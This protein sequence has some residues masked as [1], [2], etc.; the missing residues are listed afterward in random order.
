LGWLAAR[1][2]HLVREI[3]ARGHEVASHGYHHQLCSGQSCIDLEMDL[4][5]SKKLLEDIL[6]G[7]VYGYRAPSFSISD[8]ILRT[9]EQIG[10]LYDS[11]YNSFGMH[12]RYGKISLNGN[13]RSGI[14]YRISDGFYELPISNL[15]IRN[16]LSFELSASGSGPNG[17][18]F[19]LPWGGGAYFRLTPA[20][21]FRKGLES[22][23]A[24]Q[25]AYVF[26]MHPWEIDPDQPRVQGV[27]RSYRFRHYINLARTERKLATV[28]RYFSDCRFITCYEY[29]KES[30]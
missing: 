9:I 7:P 26:Y 15:T 20:W 4:C 27:S 3:H 23:L 6:G 22:I 5:D 11:S 1:L 12:G 19:V 25:G 29:L 17:P 24:R 21:I 28:L 10:F 13:G 8:D 30:A 16:P 14:A 2:P 18:G